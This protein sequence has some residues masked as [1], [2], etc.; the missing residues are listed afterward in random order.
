MNKRVILITGTPCTG[1]TTVAKQLNE[2]LDALY[3]NLTEL[4]K[5]HSL[6]I[7]EDKTRKTAIIDE[8]KLCAK[9]TE[10]IDASEK[11][12]VI[13]DSHYAAAIVPR[14]YAP[15]VFVLRRNPVELRKFMEKRG[16]SETKLWENLSSE[17]LDVCLVEALQKHEKE[18]VCELDITGKPVE[19]VVNEILAVLNENK[20]CFVGQVDW[21]TMLEKDGLLDKYLKVQS[22]T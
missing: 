7:G 12:M 5:T 11:S 19:V 10:T 20:K 16:F 1:K 17:I 3:I 22:F 18:R 4:A 6:I 21:L 14:Y 8:E 13:V 15:R 2:K 9:V